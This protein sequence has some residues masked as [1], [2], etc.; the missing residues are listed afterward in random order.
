MHLSLPSL[1]S[2]LTL[3]SASPA[4]MRRPL[5]ARMPR[6]VRADSGESTALDGNGATLTHTGAPFPSAARPTHNTL[7]LALALTPHQM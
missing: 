6:G 4:G 3:G 7:S 2:V 5:P 1:L